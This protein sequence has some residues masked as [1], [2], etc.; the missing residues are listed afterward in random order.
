RAAPDGTSIDLVLSG[1]EKAFAGRIASRFPA[2]LKEAVAHALRDDASGKHLSL[3]VRVGHPGA[4]NAAVRLMRDE[5]AKPDALLELV[6]LFGEVPQEVGGHALL[7]I[8]RRSPSLPI[9]LAAVTSLQRY[10]DP[11]LAAEV[12]RLY[13]A[14]WK[15]LPDL[16]AAAQTML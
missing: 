6:R 11:D 10:D 1:L 14:E 5:Q 12:L 16:Q 15:P 7:D 8:L 4:V 2:E 13:T 3:G 9:R